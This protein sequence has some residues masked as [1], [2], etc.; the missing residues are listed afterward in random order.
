MKPRAGSLRK[1]T[2]QTLSQMNQGTKRY[3]QINK[4]SNEKRD[5][6]TNTEEIK[7]I[8]KSYCKTV[9]DKIR[10]S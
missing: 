1:P 8:I 10:K 9:L 2:R 6:T 7:R 5:I 3:I 4:I